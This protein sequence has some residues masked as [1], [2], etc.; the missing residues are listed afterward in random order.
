MIDHITFGVSDF[1][2]SATF[3]DRA[4]GPLGIKRL[5]DDTS[6]AIKI[7]GY[8]DT[9]PGFWIAEHDATRGKLHIAFAAENRE[10]VDAF[11]RE[12]LASG[13]MDNGGPGCRPHYHPGY[14]AAFVFD[15]D[16]HNIE[17]VFHDQSEL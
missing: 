7:A 12:A 10:A 5:F 1:A 13:G 15:P 6:G 8:G 4:L 17:A 3:Y 9:R 14:Y 11:Y 16:G 2:T